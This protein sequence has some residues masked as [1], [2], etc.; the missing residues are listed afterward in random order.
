MKR[1]AVGCLLAPRPHCA[2]RLLA[3]R[4]SGAQGARLATS[5]AAGERTPRS[6]LCHATRAPGRYRPSQLRH[7]RAGCASAS[8]RRGPAATFLGAPSARRAS[9]SARRR[10]RRRTTGAGAG[11]GRR[12]CAA[13]ARYA[14]ET[15]PP[16]VSSG[17]TAPRAC[18]LRVGIPVKWRLADVPGSRAKHVCG[19]LL[20]GK[21]ERSARPAIPRCS[22]VR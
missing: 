13:R 9:P 10:S 11:T 15:R 17:A 18:R 14:T 22:M 21:K 20:W 12:H 3:R 1:D 5:A 16:E 19:R 8:E 4:S 2:L 7:G 6:A